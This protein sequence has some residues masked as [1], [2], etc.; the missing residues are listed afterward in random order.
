MDERL[1][2]EIMKNFEGKSTEELLSFWKENNKEKWSEEA[3][4]SMR[5]I[6]VARGESLPIRTEEKSGKKTLH[7]IPELYNLV[8][9]GG[10]SRKALNIIAFIGIFI[11][12][13][14]IAL[15]FTFLGKQK[16]GYRYVMAILVI[17]IF[18]RR[19]VPGIEILAS[20]IYIS[21]WIHANLVLS[22]CK[23]LARKR[24]AEIESQGEININ[25]EIEKGLLF[26]RALRD[27]G[28]GVDLLRKSLQMADGDPHLLNLAGVVMSDYKQYREAADFFDR[29]LANTN[30]KI[31]IKQV[32]KNRNY[33]QKKMSK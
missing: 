20:V 5:R 14:L 4:E 30:D 26:Y 18:G 2:K 17:L 29:L 1:A 12:G 13:W 27:K 32:Q 16:P 33:V 21:G 19:L 24:I 31:L 22:H 8:L 28:K 15:V 6:L 7:D 10:L 23:T 11:F 3:F 9:G 25:T